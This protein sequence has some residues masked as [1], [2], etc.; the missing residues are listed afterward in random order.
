M[1]STT[2]AAETTVGLAA[3]EVF[4]LFG[5]PRTSSW[6]FGAR[7]DRVETGATISMRLPVDGPGGRHGMD[8]LGRLS[9]VVPGAVLVVEHTQPWRGR[10]TVRFVPVSPA[11]TRVQVR[12]RIPPAGVH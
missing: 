4:A 2:V 9:Q 6:L 1:T 3:H 5:T 11:R 12:A 10:L 7:C 8:V